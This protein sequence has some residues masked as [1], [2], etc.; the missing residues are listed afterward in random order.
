MKIR[1]RNSIVALAC[2]MLAACGRTAAQKAA[3]A[4]L[5]APTP[6]TSGVIAEGVATIHA[7]VEKIDHKTRQV[8]LKRE[9]GSKISFR[10]DNSV[11]RLDQVVPGDVVVARYYESLAYRILEPGEKDMGTQIAGGVGTEPGAKPA[12]AGVSIVTTTAKITAID[13]KSSTVTLTGPDGEPD[14]IK[15]RDPK[16][17]EAVQVGDVV[18]FSYTEAV[19]ISVEEPG[20]Q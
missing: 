2:L 7:T 15:V 17:L 13:R 9:D 16:R 20:A 8:T 5:P 10:V 3:Q 14:E 18:E 1:V 12:A 11:Q 6:I 4:P 19:A